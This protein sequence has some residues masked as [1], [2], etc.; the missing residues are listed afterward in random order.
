MLFEGYILGLFLSLEYQDEVSA[1]V[2]SIFILLFFI[3]KTLKYS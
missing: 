1:I 2:C 3:N